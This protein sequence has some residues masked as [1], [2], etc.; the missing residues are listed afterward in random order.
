MVFLHFQSEPAAEVKEEEIESESKDEAKENGTEAKIDPEDV[1]ENDSPE[2]PSDKKTDEV[3]G[4][5]F[6]LVT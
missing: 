2:L 3:F 1:K 4:K 5:F 6:V